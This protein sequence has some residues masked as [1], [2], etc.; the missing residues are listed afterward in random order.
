MGFSPIHRFSIF[1]VLHSKYQKKTT[2]HDDIGSLSSPKKVGSEVF[3]GGFCMLVDRFRLNHGNL[4][5]L[6]PP[7]FPQG[8]YRTT[9]VN[10]HLIRPALFPEE[11]VALGGWD[12]LRLFEKILAW[13]DQHEASNH[14]FSM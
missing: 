11:N 6:G 10:N 12:T 3:F 9:V 1:I 13:W 14:Y 4:L 5:G 2:N 8:I 7:R